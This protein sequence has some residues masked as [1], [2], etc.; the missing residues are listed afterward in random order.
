MHPYARLTPGP[1]FRPLRATLYFAH[2]FVI[3]PSKRKTIARMLAAL[4]TLRHGPV[5][6]DGATHGAVRRLQDDGIARLPDLLSAA[7]VRDIHAWLQSCPREASGAYAL[8]VVLNC[9]HVLRV[10]SDPRALAVAGAYLGCKPTLSSIGIRWSACGAQSHAVQSFHR[11][12]D[13]WRFVK[14]FVYLTDVD[15]TSGPHT[16][17]RGSH[18]TKARL[19]ARPYPPEELHKTY[20]ADAILRVFG[21]AGTSFVADTYGIHKGDVPV[22]RPR[23]IL[24]IEYS[25]LPNFALLYA[26]VPVHAPDHPIDSYTNRLVVARPA[27]AR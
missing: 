15:A 22:S 12:L 21:E 10:I 24:Q 6:H 3:W 2:R 9:P 18:K 17:V 5:P 8:D 7:E 4:V 19:R 1:G 11:D 20:G 27:P 25:V 14:V 23:L 16:Y 26:P 13:D